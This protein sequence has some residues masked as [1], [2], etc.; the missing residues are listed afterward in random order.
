MA[1]KFWVGG[2]GNWDA[3]TTT[4]WAITTGGA[5]GTAVPVA[6]DVVT[7]DGASGGGV[8]TMTT[9]PNVAS[10]FMGAF[11][12]T[13]D[14]NGQSPVMTTQFS[15]NGSGTRTLKMGSGNWTISGN[16]T[17]VVSFLNM[18]GLTLDRS[19]GG[20]FVCN[21]SGATGTRNVQAGQTGGSEAASPDIK[22]TAGTDIFVTNAGVTGLRIHNLDFTGFTGTW[23]INTTPLTLFGNLTIG[24][25]LTMGAT[26]NSI[27]FSGTVSQQNVTTNGVTIPVSVTCQGTQV[28]Q[29]Q[30]NMRIGV[31][32]AVTLT[33]TSGT[34]DLNG[35][36][37]THFGSFATGSG[38]K[39]LAFK[40]GTYDNIATT[41][42][43]VWNNANNAGF[44]M[45]AVGG[46]L[47]KIEGSTVNIRTFAGGGAT[48]PVPVW[49]TNATAAG[50]LSIT[51]SSTFTA[52]KCLD[53]NGQTIK[54]TAAT[55]TTLATPSAW[56]IK[57]AAGN[58]ITIAS[59]TAATHTISAAG[60]L[61]SGDFMSLTNSIATGGAGFYAGLNSVDGGGNTGW[62]F[63]QVPNGNFF[64]FFN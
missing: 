30:D 36:T 11:T 44:T 14:G 57:G 38:T 16:A 5:G 6:G 31:A 18:T 26:G 42:T 52:L 56:Q 4:N 41:V 3:V 17:T 28:V 13:L 62:F 58:L 23:N 22:V 46:G 12:G 45:T 24:T 51:G 2:T 37:L 10:I 34:L 40:G 15:C 47:I 53:T 7:F 27:L 21:Y 55:T 1:S 8:V 59:L 50:Q 33:L 63:S 29:L 43:T 64:Q 32:A 20:V 35:K 49:Y 54:F 9:S 61:V 19:G 48:Y 25:G 39:T 60:G